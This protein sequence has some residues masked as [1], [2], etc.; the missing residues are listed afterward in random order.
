MKKPK[1]LLHICCVGCGVYISQELNKEFETTLYFYNPNIYP[2]DEYLRRLDESR[3]IASNYGLELI[4]DSYEHDEWLEKVKGH[5]FDQEKGERCHICY[6]NRLNNAA[7]KAKELE[8]EYFATTLTISPHKDSGIINEI[9]K[10]LAQKHG[11][12]FLDRDFKKQDGFKK[13]SQL[14]RELGLY[15]Q[16]YCG[17]EFS[18][19]KED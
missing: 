14:S 4:L 19:R 13:S 17:C 12:N 10:R 15:R 11:I 16:N 5:E 2:Q 1:L 18:I 3:K 8:M 9:G 7:A 6:E